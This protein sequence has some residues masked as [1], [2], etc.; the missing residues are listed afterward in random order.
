MGI[1][2]SSVCIG[3]QRNNG[4][5]YEVIWILACS[6]VQSCAPN[7]V[8]RYRMQA[9]LIRGSPEYFESLQ[10]MVSSS[11]MARPAG[12]AFGSGRDADRGM[13]RELERSTNN[14]SSESYSSGR[15]L[16]MTGTTSFSQ[17]A[18]VMRLRSQ[19]NDL[20]NDLKMT[21]DELGRTRQLLD[22]D[23][24]ASLSYVRE[25]D[26]LQKKYSEQ[27]V[28]LQSLLNQSEKVRRELE[29]QVR[30]S[31]FAPLI[32]WNCS[33]CTPFEPRRRWR[34]MLIS[35]TCARPLASAIFHL[36]LLA[37]ASALA[38]GCRTV[39]LGGS[40]PPTL[41]T[42]LRLGQVNNGRAREEEFHEA[43][44]R[45]KEQAEA[46]EQYYA[47]LKRKVEMDRGGMERVLQ[48]EREARVQA[49]L[50]RQQA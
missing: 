25:I 20:E 13:K 41:I 28:E 42:R 16:E 34:W 26:T 40:P 36:P 6:C 43:F 10:A 17:D 30:H 33:I 5:L 4:D 15:A 45:A 31:T 18:E 12:S 9:V 29:I 7:C 47:D 32:P 8:Q 37:L 23:R 49:D 3:F 2:G 35:Y 11:T 50:A 21:K 24:E 46:R 1:Q 19:V 22:H 39:G 14:M 38:S 48:Q 44:R 27:I